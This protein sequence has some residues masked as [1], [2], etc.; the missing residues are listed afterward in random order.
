MVPLA[1]SPPKRR[2]REGPRRRLMD[3]AMSV[4]ARF[5]YERATVD[6]IVREA[7]FSK[8]AF[9][10]HFESKE[11]LFWEM[12]QERIDAQQ[13]SLRQAMDVEATVEENERRVLEAIFHLDRQD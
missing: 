6:E 11:D 8:G 7:G 1:E 10:V 13:E 12:L 3:S 5:G 9:Y 2:R 4:F